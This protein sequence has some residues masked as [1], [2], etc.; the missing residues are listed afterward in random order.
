MS[1]RRGLG[2]GLDALI[3]NAT[4]ETQTVRMIPVDRIRE[5]RSQPRTR[6]DEHALDE[7]AASIREHGVIQPIIVCEDETGGFELI[8]GERRWRAARNAGLLEIP[9]L[10]KSSTTPQQL[11]ELALVENVQR[12]DLNPLEEGEAYQT[13]KDEFGL[14]DDEIAKRVGKSRVAVVNMRRLIKLGTS[15]RQALLDNKISAGHGRILLRFEDVATQ[16]VM[17]DL[18]LRRDLSVRETERIA[19]IALQVK[20]APDVRQAL[21]VGTITLAQAQALLRIDDVGQQA[22]VLELS[23]SVGLSSRETE[24]FCGLVAEGVSIEAAI[25]QVRDRKILLG[26]VPPLQREAPRPPADEVRVP[27]EMDEDSDLPR[28][29][30]ASNAQDAE[31]RRIFEALLGT[32]VQIVRSGG[33]IKLIITLYTDDQLQQIYERLGGE[34]E[35]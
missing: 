25:S 31:T 22:R 15:A 19:D 9:A 6:F 11:L 23:L 16:S 24:R 4:P 1:R 18:I 30:P 10:V 34:D 7:L 27:R 28:S 35:L 13:L 20:V 26:G 5:N 33:T 32:P 2:S 12:S 17:L 29:T 8:A 14:S 3:G 21:L